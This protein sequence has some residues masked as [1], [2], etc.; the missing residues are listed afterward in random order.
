MKKEEKK[1]KEK[2]EKL[3]PLSPRHRCN[4]FQNEKK[5]KKADEKR[6]P[7]LLF[8]LFLPRLWR[9]AHSRRMHTCSSLRVDEKV[10]QSD[11]REIVSRIR[12]F[13]FASKGIY[14]YIYI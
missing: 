11:T 3:V 10:H 4:L 6:L 9:A 13:F 2:R 12:S 7:L 8:S 1:K 14:I 5:K